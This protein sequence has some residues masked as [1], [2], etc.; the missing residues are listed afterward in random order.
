[1]PVDLNNLSDDELR[2]L[3]VRMK[4][5]KAAPK[6][7]AGEQA[8]LGVQ[9]SLQG[10]GRNIGIPFTDV[11]VSHGLESLGAVRPY[12]EVRADVRDKGGWIAPTT[13]VATDI[14]AVAYPASAAVRGLK[15]IQRLGPLVKALSA[16]GLGGIASR[17]VVEGTVGAM[18]TGQSDNPVW[19]AAQGAFWGGVAA[20]VTS[21]IAR[22]FSGM[23]KPSQEATELLAQ[24]IPVTP[25]Q[26]AAPMGM[27]HAVKGVE[28]ALTSAPLTGPILQSI[29]GKGLE[30]LRAKAVKEALPPGMALPRSAELQPLKA[31]REIG[32]EFSKQYDDALRVTSGKDLTV[33][34]GV[35]LE[36]MQRMRVPD[37]F[38][39]TLMDVAFSDPDAYITQPRL[40]HASK[41]IADAVDFVTMSPR[42]VFKAQ[43]DLRRAANKIYKNS[44]AMLEEVSVADAYR[45]AADH[46]LDGLSEGL[47]NGGKLQEL[48]GP[49]KRFVNLLHETEK[50]K[51][52]GGSLSSRAIRKAAIASNNKRLEN[53][54]RTA[55]EVLPSSTPDS[56]TAGR[57][58]MLATLGAAGGYFQGGDIDSAA[59]GAAI[60][61]GM[62]LP[63]M[64]LTTPQGARFV[65]GQYPWQKTLGAL[66]PQ[67]GGLGGGILG[68]RE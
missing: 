53:L 42:Q 27:G 66:A 59:K 1:M 10:L 50:M 18:L 12:E 14:A 61:A 24:G 55:E 13:E 65:F 21:L 32:D 40:E 22:P 56:G 36:D 45:R 5:E 29:R 62:M 20:P 31:L 17:G 44:N 34:G 63:G 2:A 68:V 9:A 37:D 16:T 6:L 19:D 35:V 23:A 38:K 25:G 64:A 3:Y 15:G 41:R 46:I 57:A 47:P 52:F 60:G 7:S 51:G 4:A 26:G 28:E 48:R 33:P 49:Y 39:R 11:D 58:A 43:S 30:K 67:L 8:A 54:T